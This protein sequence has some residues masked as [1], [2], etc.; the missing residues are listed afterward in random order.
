MNAGGKYGTV[1]D[2]LR[3]LTIITSAG[4]MIEREFKV[5]KFDYRS[6]QLAES[7]IIIEATFECTSAASDQLLKEY[8]RILNEKRTTQPM[9]AKSCGCVFRNPE[10]DSAGALIDACGCKGET[11]GDISVSDVHA[12]FFVN[13]GKGSSRDMVALMQKVRD[14]VQSKYTVELKPEIVFFG[15]CG[16]K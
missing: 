14:C 12:N 13:Q 1:S 11:I 4:E 3:S 9:D 6:A 5:M 8:N 16:W 7:D 2:A 10:G 15:E